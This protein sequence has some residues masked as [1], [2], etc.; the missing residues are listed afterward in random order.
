MHFYLNLFGKLKK[1]SYIKSVPM[2]EYN[3]NIHFLISFIMVTNFINE[4]GN[5]VRNQ[6]VIYDNN[7]ITFQSYS[8]TICTIENGKVSVNRSMWQYSRTT[9]KYLYQFLRAN[10]WKVYRNKDVQKLIDNGTFKTF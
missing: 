5:A 3:L 9:A 1:I 2:R 6:F 7:K 8:T 10:G 4:R